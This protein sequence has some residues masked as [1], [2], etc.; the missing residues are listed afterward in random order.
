MPGRGKNPYLHT[1]VALMAARLLTAEAARAL[2]EAEAA[3][4]PPFF[5]AA[6]A[7][8]LLAP[9]E[10]AE[11]ALEQRR[12]A[13][14]LAE[15]LILCRALRGRSRAFLLYWTHLFELIN[16]KAILRRRLAGKDGAGVRGSLLDMG[17]FAALP[18]EALL[19]ADSPAEMLRRLES[20]P[21]GEIA[22]RARGAAVAQGDFFT[23]EASLDRRFHAG[24]VARARELRCSDPRRFLA[25]IG[26]LVDSVNLVWLL[27]YRFAY[28]VPAAETYYLLIDSPF[29]LSGER[30]R[31][32]AGH[33]SA[34]AL[35]ADLPEP[36]RSRLAHL[37]TAEAVQLQLSRHLAELADETLRRSPSAFVRAFAYLLR[38]DAD[39]RLLAGVL[40]SER[41]GLSPALRAAAFPLPTELADAAA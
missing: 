17:P 30:L 3:A 28:K 22:G 38:R 7:E 13:I 12:L 19:R 18:V 9:G 15:I 2:L 24:L 25:L 34:A 20:T 35:L 1:R 26:S 39:L 10:P 32:L 8:A 23:L 5:A 27:R 6:G 31:R 21:Y 14:L 36:L 40:R 41:L 37:E 11:R 29:R 16:L 33:R 4:L